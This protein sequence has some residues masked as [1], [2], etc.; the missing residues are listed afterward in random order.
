MPE[1]KQTCFE[2][3]C[4]GRS[5]DILGCDLGHDLGVRLSVFTRQLA[6]AMC[7]LGFGCEADAEPCVILKHEVGH[8]L[9]VCVFR[10]GGGFRAENAM[11]VVW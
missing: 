11:C 4:L 3:R 6:R 1:A 9:H 10:L 2:I 8:V 5:R 7:G